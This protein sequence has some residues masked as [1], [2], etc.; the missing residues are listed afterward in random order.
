MQA[1]WKKAGLGIAAAATAVSVAAPAQAQRY[2]RYYHHHGHGDAVGAALLGGV[3]GLALGA[4]IASDHNDRYYD[5]RYYDDGYYDR[6][7][8]DA[9]AYYAPP[10]RYEYRP[11]YRCYSQWRYDPYYRSRVRVRVCR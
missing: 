2:H 5:N 8:Y 11:R 10:V 9:P 3:A 1:F 6:G 4:A 7:Y